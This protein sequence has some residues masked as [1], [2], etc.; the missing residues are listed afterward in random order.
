MSALTDFEGAVGKNVSLL[1]FYSPF[2]DCNRTALRILWL[3]RRCRWKRSGDH[4]AIPFFSWSSRR[5]TKDDV[6]QP[7]FQ[8]AEV[9]NGRYDT[10]I[11]S[12]AENS[13]EWGHPYFLR[14]DWE[15]NGFWFPWG[16]RVNG[17]KDGRIRQGLAPRPR[18]LHRVGAANA[19]WVW[20]PNIALHQATA[21]LR[22]RSTRAT[23]TST[24]PAWTASTGAT[25][26]HSPGW[27]SF[28]EVFRPPTSEVL[29]IAPDKPMAIGETASEERGGVQ[30]GLDHAT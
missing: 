23:P 4:G 10:F 15:M 5:P 25:T 17:N 14:F 30:G 18:H 11:E 27:L 8:L 20:C 1:A 9:I 21:E 3:S 2:A 19:T 22:A 7:G 12:F 29:K 6:R 26:A 24:G 28:N 16:A 13:R